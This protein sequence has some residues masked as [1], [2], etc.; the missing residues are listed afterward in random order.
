MKLHRLRLQAFGPFAGTES[1]D[2]D[3]LASSG[4]FLLDGPTGAGKSSI[5]DAICFAIYG[6]LPGARQGNRQIRSD[7]AAAHDAPEVSCE[8]SVGRRRFEVTRAPA[9]MRPSSRAKSG[10]VE[11][12]ASSTLRERVDGHWQVLSTRNDE[13]GQLLGGALGLSRDQFTKVIMLP[14][15]GFADFLR[16]KDTDREALLADLFDTSDYAG[17]EEEFARRYTDERRAFETAETQLETRAGALLREAHEFLG[18]T[19]PQS[20][21]EIAAT[22]AEARYNALRPRIHAVIDELEIA[23]QARDTE[24]QKARAA[25]RQLNEQVTAFAKLE[26]FEGLQVTNRESRPETEQA[27]QALELDAKAQRITAYLRQ[28]EQARAQQEQASTAANTALCEAEDLRELPRRADG[29]PDLEALPAHLDVLREQLATARAAVPEERELKDLYVS[30]AEQSTRIEQLD[31]ELVTQQSQIENLAASRQELEVEDLDEVAASGAVH[32]AT[33]ALQ[34]AGELLEKV[35]EREKLREHRLASH[36][37]LADARSAT[38]A[39][40][41]EHAAAWQL[42]LSQSALRLAQQLRA[43]EPCM[44][45]GATEHPA[46]ARSAQ[47][48]PE[49]ID[50]DRLAELEQATEQRRATEQRALAA[51]EKAET[52]YQSAVSATESVDLAAATAALTEREQQLKDAKA[53]LQQVK[54]RLKRLAALEAQQGKAQQRQNDITVELSTEREKLRAGTERRALLEQRIA[55]LRGGYDSLTELVTELARRAQRTDLVLETQ[56]A[57]KTAS[58]RL[59]QSTEEWEKQRNAAGFATDADHTAALLEQNQRAERERLVHAADQR[60]ARLATLAE[61]AEVQLAAALRADGGQAPGESQCAA[62]EEAVD[63][64]EQAYELASERLA[65][66]R[67]RLERLDAQRDEL[68]ALRAEYG[69]LFASYR[70]LKALAEVM[71]GQGENRLKMTLR[72]YVLAARLEEVAV[73][74]TERLKVMTS[75][76]YELHHD[77]RARGNAKSGLG[78]VV[79]DAWT[80]KPRATQTLSGGETFMASLALALGLADVITQHSGAIDMQTL[81]VDEGFGSLDTDTLDQVMGALED[82]RSGGRSVGVVSHVSD[83]KQRIAQRVTVH[84]TQRGSR[85]AYEPLGP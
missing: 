13:V 4:L 10:F 21:E 80:L 6:S 26:E 53:A 81:F 48:E 3:A 24:R 27:R 75:N 17:I 65:V 15:G 78:L 45:C 47:T 1:I 77:D 9:W 61:S 79:H 2:F 22:E 70:R 71:R 62:A 74:A 76:R 34:E 51:F 52:N 23:R 46:P 85:I 11:Q 31:A 32:E 19:M 66:S 20:P 84:K 44:V 49:L 63:E 43:G 55:T 56:R 42:Y 33:V 25:Q 73:A 64:A 82:L 69:E 39:A 14:Q 50:E 60:A 16:A 12:K 58:G 41:K 57:L 54:D 36:E 68:A 5:L 67:S 83:M 40:A 72:T 29:A 35:K 8:F 7:H 18:E 30:L 37:A 38:S 28:Q 59:E